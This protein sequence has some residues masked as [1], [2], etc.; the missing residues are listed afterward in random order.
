VTTII[1]FTYAAVSV[2]KAHLLMWVHLSF[3]K[4]PKGNESGTGKWYL[5]KKSLLLTV[6][7]SY[8]EGAMA[9]LLRSGDCCFV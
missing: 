9:L 7:I 1:F 3:I 8:S 4:Y 6:T 5:K 2:Y